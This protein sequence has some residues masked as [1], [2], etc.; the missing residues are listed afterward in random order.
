MAAD[1]E[2]PI[3]LEDIVTEIDSGLAPGNYFNYP[4]HDVALQAEVD[5]LDGIEG[6]FND[7][8]F[9]ADSRQLYFDPAHPPKG[10]LPGTSIIFNRISAGEVMDCIKPVFVTGKASTPMITQGAIGNSHFIN[11]L[12]ILACVPKQITSLLVSDKN[13]S[14]GI[15]TFKFFKAGKWRYVHI[16]DKIPCR[17]SG[18]VNFSRNEDPNETF[19]MLLEKA[20]AKLHGCYESLVHGLIERTIMDLTPAGHCSVSAKC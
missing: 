4:D 16:D 2:E 19:S 3:D 7:E 12:R 10:S 11:S 14:Q 15:Y 5:L 20:Y 18:R 9:P 13:A 8:A 17:Q 1:E 6:Y